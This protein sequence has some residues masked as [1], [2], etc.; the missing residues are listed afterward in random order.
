[1][2]LSD[3]WLLFRAWGLLLLVD[4]GLRLV[5]FRRVQQLLRLEQ[6]RETLCQTG[7]AWD[8]IQ[9]TQWLVRVAAEHHLYPM[10]CL[11]Q[12]LVLRWFL[13]RQGIS[14]DLRFGVQRNAGLLRAHAWLEYGGQPISQR[15][16]LAEQFAALT[17]STQAVEQSLRRL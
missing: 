8:K 6:Q 13:A 17:T 14:T 1:M 3:W 5:P 4:L 10:R 2:S 12:A 16:D 15:P 9:R 7:E 11:R